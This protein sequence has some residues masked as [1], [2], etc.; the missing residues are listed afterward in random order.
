MKEPAATHT[1]ATG[2]VLCSTPDVT[3][4][5]VSVAHFGSLFEFQKQSTFERPANVVAPSLE[6]SCRF[7][8]VTWSTYEASPAECT[9][10][11]AISTAS[12]ESHWWAEIAA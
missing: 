9:D 10:M 12:R 3:P 1:T 4:S 5:P 11:F 7:E 2:V 8:A 6:R